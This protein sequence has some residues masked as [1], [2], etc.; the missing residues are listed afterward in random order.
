MKAILIASL[1]AAQT[2]ATASPAF[3]ASL[4]DQNQTTQ[5]SRGVFAGARLRIALGGEKP[6]PRAG[7]AFAPTLRNERSDGRSNL[8]FGEG[9]EFGFADSAKPRLMLAGQPIGAR[10]LGAAEGKEKGKEEEKDTRK[11]PS[12]LGTIGIIAGGLLVVGGI[13]FAI[14]LRE[15]HEHSE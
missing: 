4:Y 14:L 13:G 2:F 15:V 1:V 12:T 10:K 7:L 9:V 5:Q 8:R 11:G 6:I 3:A